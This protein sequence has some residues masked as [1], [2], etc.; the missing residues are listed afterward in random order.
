MAQEA[1]GER[2]AAVRAAERRADVE[3]VA[4]RQFERRA[5][6]EFAERYLDVAIQ[7]YQEHVAALAGIPAENGILHDENCIFFD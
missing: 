7:C 6:H 5:A 2:E 4:A 1:R 3:V